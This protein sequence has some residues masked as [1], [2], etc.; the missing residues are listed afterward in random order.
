MHGQASD[1]LERFRSQNASQKP[2]RGTS[3]RPG[4][5]VGNRDWI[6]PIECT[7]DALVVFPSGQR[8]AIA[9]LV[10]GQAGR[11]P[12]VEIIQQ[13]VA[14]RQATVRP[15]EPPYRPMIRFRVRPDGLRSYHLAY[16][17]LEVLQLPMTRENVDPEEGKAAKP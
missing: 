15:G 3:A 13:M 9:Q 5:L 14:R 6:I 16:P 11:N 2:G 1:P 8:I 12:L 7:A 17:A 4:P 10:T